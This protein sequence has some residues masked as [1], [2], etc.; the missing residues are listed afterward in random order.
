MKDI[1]VF[2][3]PSRRD[4]LSSGAHCAI[5]LARTHGAHLSA[6][7]ADVETDLRDLPPEPDIR[8]VERAGAKPATSSERVARTAELVQSAATDANVSC[9]ILQTENQPV[10]LRERMI[11]CT[12]VHDVLII[13]AR[14][15][16]DSPR[17]ELVEA[18][19]FA[20]GRPI[21]FVPP[22]TPVLAK[23]RIVVAWDGTRSAVRAVRD[24]LPLLAQSREVLV[25]SVIDDKLFPIPHSGDALCRYLAR[26]HVDAKFGTIHRETLNIGASLLA[27]A[28]QAD[29]DLLVMG[30]FAHGFERELMLGSATRDV[31]NAR[32]EIPVLLSH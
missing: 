16:L 25:V 2:L 30:A 31:F 28:Q 8:Q 13:D 19:L 23:G 7:I 9:D 17:K 15:P 20:S 21:V 18:A 1:L 29:A 32:I 26:W 22:N 3:S 11:H 6:L 10:S 5:A 4:D 27:Y 14:G 12:Q 24:A